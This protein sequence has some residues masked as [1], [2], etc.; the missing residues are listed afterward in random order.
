MTV[1]HAAKASR[2]FAA[3]AL[4]PNCE[5]HWHVKTHL[6]PKPPPQQSPQLQ[7]SL[8][9]RLFSS[10]EAYCVTNRVTHTPRRVLP[11]LFPANYTHVR[12]FSNQWYCSLFAVISPLQPK[13]HTCAPADTDCP[14]LTYILALVVISLS[15]ANLTPRLASVLADTHFSRQS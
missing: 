3:A 14:S 2:T 10:K 13:S 1:A 4:S 12:S 11:H 6:H 15:L 5:P 8:R 7:P 9:H